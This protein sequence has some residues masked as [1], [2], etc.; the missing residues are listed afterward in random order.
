MILEPKNG[1]FVFGVNLQQKG[2]VLGQSTIEQS[3]LGNYE[4]MDFFVES[5]SEVKESNK[6]DVLCQDSVK[7][8]S[9]K[10]NFQFLICVF[11]HVYNTNLCEKILNEFS[12]NFDKPN[13]KGNVIKESLDQCK[14]CFDGICESAEDIIS[15]NSLSEFD[16]YG[17]VLSCL[18]DCVIDECQEKFDELYKNQKDVLFEVLLKYKLCF[19]ERIDLSLGVLDEV[20]KF[21]AKESFDELKNNGIFYLKDVITFLDVIEKNKEEI[22]KI[23]NFKPIEI[24][25][26]D[27]KEM[28]FKKLTEKIG[29][30][31][32]FSNNKNLILINFKSYFWDNIAKKSP[33][34]TIGDIKIFHQ[35]REK[36]VIYNTLVNNVFKED[37][38]N[39]IKKEINGF[40][41]KGVFIRQLDERIKNYIEQNDKVRNS[42]I[43][44]LIKNYDVYYK[45]GIYKNKRNP[46][47]LKRI[48]LE[49]IFEDDLE[50]YVYILLEKIEKIEDF[51]I[52]LE[53]ININK[54]GNIKLKYLN[55]LI[56]K[57][58]IAIKKSLLSDINPKIIKSIANLAY[59]MI[60]NES[61]KNLCFLKDVINGSELL[62][63]N[64]KNKIYLQL[65]G[66]CNNNK[67]ENIINFISEIYL[68]TLKKDNLNEFVDFILSLTA[69]K[70]ND[71]IENFDDKYN[72]IEEEYYSLEKV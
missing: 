57:Y 51:D 41:K 64:L 27:D 28:D 40:Y 10:P 7:L 69:E 52:I 45:D 38:E 72:L 34:K 60:I 5:L 37:K 24:P 29:K 3:A 36:L 31:L 56:N 55:N 71:L 50:N 46:E 43:I 21:T 15:S 42:E 6:I 59:F 35:L 18:N 13:Q 12:K 1:T 65:I 14:Y 67:Q 30:I 61:E 11:I 16:F 23:K 26:F 53:L 22:I 49:T 19:K 2:K 33:H 54:L 17:L 8:Y 58:K 32:E 62:D 68:Q 9:K 66:L 47:I 20:I 63:K 70:S 4:I 48:N 25:Q 44:D 39:P